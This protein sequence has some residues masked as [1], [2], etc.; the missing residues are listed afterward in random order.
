M[1]LIWGQKRT[2]KSLWFFLPRSTKR[3]SWPPLFFTRRK[4]RS[5]SS[6][7]R[8]LV[9][10]LSAISVA[11]AGFPSDTACV[12]LSVHHWEKLNKVM[13]AE[14]WKYLFSQVWKTNHVSL[15]SA[16]EFIPTFGQLPLFGVFRTGWRIAWINLPKKN[17]TEYMNWSYTQEKT[18][19]LASMQHGTYPHVCCPW[20]LH[21]GDWRWDVDWTSLLCW[22]QDWG[23]CLRSIQSHK[24]PLA[25]HKHTVNTQNTDK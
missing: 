19:F 6:R 15:F 24:L 9:C 17:Q 23:H 10:G 1:C 13:I 5:L 18:A 14:K 4:L 8:L 2:N 25:C 22:S 21:F 16:T 12:L 11:F 7:L 20:K 3:Q